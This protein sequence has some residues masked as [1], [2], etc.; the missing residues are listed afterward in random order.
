VTNK[1]I[2]KEYQYRRA[3]TDI[4]EVIK[5]A[6]FS[7]KFKAG[8]K[9]P[10]ERDLATQFQVGRMT[11]REAL[12]TLETKGLIA[13]RKGS[14][15]GAF[16]QP[17]PPN[18]IADIIIDNLQLDG[19]T[20]PEVAESRVVLERSIVKYVVKKATSKDMKEIERNIEESKNLLDD[21]SPEGTLE[22]STK[23]IEFH[24]LLAKSAHITPLV[25]FHSV[26]AKWVLQRLIKQLN[27]TKKQR[28]SSNQEHEAIFEA[29]KNKDVGLSQE[30]VERHI[31]KVIRAIEKNAKKS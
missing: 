7:K 16:I 4:A 24:H 17:A 19:V 21:F 10:P 30:L 1:D 15:G 12:R 31:R 26:M 13:I 11:I 3:S 6:I 9:L 28:L 8:D 14:S 18:Q 22:F 5:K 23:S 2:F 27:P 25:V 29:I 20:F